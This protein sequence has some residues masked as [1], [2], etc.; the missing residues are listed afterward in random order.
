[1]AYGKLLLSI[2][3][4]VRYVLDQ[5]YLRFADFSGI[6]PAVSM[7]RY[8]ADPDGTEFEMAIYYNAAIANAGTARRMRVRGI[9]VFY[10]FH[11]PVPVRMRLSEGWKE[12]LK[13]IAA[14]YCSIAMLR[15]S[16]AVLV[17]SAYARELYDRH[18]RDYNPN[19]HTFPLLF[20][21][22]FNCGELALK[23][24]VRPYFSFLG[25]AVKAHDF[26]GFCAF[27]KYA[28]RAGSSIK[29]AIATRTDLSAC[30]TGDEELARYG[31]EG[32]ILIQHGRTL[33]NEEMN[34]YCAQSFCVWNI[35][36]CSTQSGALV[37][38]FM[39][40]TPVIATQ[41]GSFPEFIHPGVNGELVER[42]N[43]YGAILATAEKI[44]LNTLTYSQGAR[45]SFKEVFF[46]GAQRGR[47]ASILI[48]GRKD[49]LKCA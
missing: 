26:E 46:Y 49:V 36:K 7:A 33:S 40:G 17:A 10:V 9:E 13:L 37:R 24:G 1:M 35:Y 34:S 31:K 41:S 48:G 16:S 4:A 15:Q 5:K 44:R 30:L 12:I 39:T 29:F 2:G 38:A 14:K 43:H 18:F 19:V 45:K 8:R 25:L 42:S 11:E 27:A 21:D 6:A 3:F 47:L 22:E 32:R 20:E 23:Q 28:I